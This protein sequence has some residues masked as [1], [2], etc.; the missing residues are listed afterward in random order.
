MIPYDHDWR[1]LWRSNG[2]LFHGRT[3]FAFAHLAWAALR[4]DSRRSSLLSFLAVALPPMRAISVMVRGFLLRA[5]DCFLGVIP[6]LSHACLPVRKCVNCEYLVLD[7]MRTG[8]H[9]QAIERPEQV[10]AHSPRPDQVR[11]CT[12]GKHGYLKV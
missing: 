5:F 3:F 1:T 2:S 10:L 11:L 4:A 8:A 6:R 9:N 7:L 12:G